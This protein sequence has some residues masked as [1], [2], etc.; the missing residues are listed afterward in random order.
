MIQHVGLIGKMGSGKSTVAKYLIQKFGF[1]HLYLAEP[2]K[3]IVHRLEHDAEYVLID[4]FILPYYDLS[5][6]QISTFIEIL[7]Q[8]KQI[9]VEGKKPRKRYQ[10]LGTDGARN[11][12]DKKIWIKILQSKLN[13]L[14]GRAVIDDVRFLNEYRDLKNDMHMIYLA[15]NPE[16]QKE[17][18]RQAYGQNL[19]MSVLNHPSEKEIEQIDAQ[20]FINANLDVNRVRK[21]V[22][23]YLRDK[24]ILDHDEY[25]REMRKI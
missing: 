13:Q 23:S 10:Y 2:I 1:T 5:N 4:K 21:E 22:A 18:L 8:T 6:R 15:I 9:P 14:D 16:V 7:Y 25:E 11:Q 12:I 17:R 20:V 19:D 3:Q 24:G